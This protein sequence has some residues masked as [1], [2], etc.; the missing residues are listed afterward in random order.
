MKTYE[1]FEKATGHKINQAK[2]EILP[3]NSNR[4]QYAHLAKDHIKIFGTY[5]GL[6]D[7]ERTWQDLK[8]AMES[9]ANIKKQ[10]LT[11]IGKTKLI[12]ATV[13]AKI[14]HPARIF[15]LKPQHFKELSTATFQTL[16]HP[17]KTEVLL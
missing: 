8:R 3:T 15:P 5:F 2:T 4:T 6:K 9:L 16:R 12:N 10:N 7:Y 11:W 17:E 13:I 1:F 14:I